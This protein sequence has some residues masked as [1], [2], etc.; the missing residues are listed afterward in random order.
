MSRIRGFALGRRDTDT[1]TMSEMGNSTT[2]AEGDDG[3]ADIDPVDVQRLLTWY[4]DDVH[5]DRHH[6]TSPHRSPGTVT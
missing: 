2:A 5:P 1:Q 3:T 6:I 4:F